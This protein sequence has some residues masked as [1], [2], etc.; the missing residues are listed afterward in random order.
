MMIFNYNGKRLINKY[1]FLKNYSLLV[2]KTLIKKGFN[3]IKKIKKFI[4]K[5]I[6]NIY[7][8]YY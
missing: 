3:Q 1:L 6:L 4:I 8:I 7:L 2:I 5:F